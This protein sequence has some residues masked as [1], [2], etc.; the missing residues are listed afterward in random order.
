MNNNIKKILIILNFTLVLALTLFSALK[1]ENYKNMDN[2]YLK[3][4]PVDPRSLMQ[5]DYMI[6]NYEISENVM[7]KICESVNE[8]HS[9][10]KK[11]Y[12]VAKIDDNKIAQFVDVVKKPFETS[13]FI[14]IAFKYNGYDIKI[15]ADTFFFQEGE[16]ETYQNAKF[17]KV[18]LIKNTLRLIELVEKF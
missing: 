13:E 5:G 8:N 16:A 15:N 3:L 18:V 7:E 2:F 11:G 6:L 4:V 1:E 17:S 10:L 12:I 9:F 14:F